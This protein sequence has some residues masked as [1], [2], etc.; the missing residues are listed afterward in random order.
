MSNRDSKSVSLLDMR[1]RKQVLRVKYKSQWCS[2]CEV[3]SRNSARE[4]SLFLVLGFCHLKYV[5]KLIFKICIPVGFS[6]AVQNHEISIF[7]K[8]PPESGSGFSLT[9]NTTSEK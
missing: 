8:V 3:E 1:V 2:L 5:V 6:T 7:C 9:V 4:S